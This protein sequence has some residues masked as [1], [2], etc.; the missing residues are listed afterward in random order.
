MKNKILFIAFVVM[1]LVA[2]TAHAEPWAH[3]YD[4]TG[5]QSW[6]VITNQGG[7]ALTVA[8]EWNQS[9]WTSSDFGWGT[10]TDGTGWTWGD[11]PWF[12]DGDNNNKRII[13]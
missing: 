9:S 3:R 1:A 11:C 10:S 13:E 2:F 7:S 4:G 12:E 6:Q 8:V 5:G